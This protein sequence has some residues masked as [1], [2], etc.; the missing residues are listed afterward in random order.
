MLSKAQIAKRQGIK[1]AA[2][3]SSQNSNLAEKAL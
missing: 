2:I 1:K 3:T